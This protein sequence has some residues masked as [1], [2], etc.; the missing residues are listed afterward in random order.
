MAWRIR[1]DRLPMRFPSRYQC[2]SILIELGLPAE[3]IIDVGV[4]EETPDLIELFPAKK[5]VLIEP[6]V[7]HADAIARNYCNIDYVLHQVAASSLDRSAHLTSERNDS[8]ES[9]TH[10]HICTGGDGVIIDCRTLDSLLAEYAAEAPFLLKIDT[11]GHEPDVL[12]GARH[13]L[14]SCAVVVIE[15]A[16][17]A[18]ADISTALDD[19]GLQLFDIV[20]LCYYHDTLTQFDGV[21]INRTLFNNDGLFPWDHQS[22]RWSDW[23]ALMSGSDRRR[24][25]WRR[26]RG[27]VR[28]PANQG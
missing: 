8:A 17:Q 25:L 6:E 7:A 20:D 21:F 9:V 1:T 22:F 11:D 24:H 5:H 18:L 4:H 23:K 10:S 3:T 27:R 2:L 12:K 19:A 14:S 13:T 26:L 15:I 16:P 28:R